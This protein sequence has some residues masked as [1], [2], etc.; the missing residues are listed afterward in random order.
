MNSLK[1]YLVVAAA[2]TALMVAS[3]PAKADTLTLDAGWSSFNFGG[4]GSSWDTS[5]TFT[6]S[7]TAYLNVADGYLSGDQ[8]A[9]SVNGSANIPTSVPTTFN[10]QIGADY[11]SAFESGGQWSAL[12]LEVGPG[13]YTVFGTTLASPFGGGSAGIELASTLDPLGPPVTV[14]GAPGPVPGAGLAG[15]AALALA[16]LYARARRA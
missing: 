14:F 4:V 6:V 5:Y 7:S 15:F 16:G 12:Q 9:V 3:A 10:Q 11:T 13:S 8:F 2:A 1:A